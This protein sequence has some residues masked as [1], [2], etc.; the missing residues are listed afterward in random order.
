MTKKST[1]LV[2]YETLSKRIQK[3]NELLDRQNKVLS[4][5]LKTL[6]EL[7]WETLILTIKEV[8]K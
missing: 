1:P 7:N 6:D 5:I 2:I 4:R 3:Q 8:T